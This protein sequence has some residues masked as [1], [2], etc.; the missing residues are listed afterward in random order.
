ENQQY[1]R[2]YP[3]E[4]YNQ[5]RPWTDRQLHLHHDGSKPERGSLICLCHSDRRL[6]LGHRDRCGWD[7]RLLCHS[8]NFGLLELVTRWE[9]LQTGSLLCDSH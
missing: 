5:L 6:T 7:H 8:G 1:R 2:D 4:E 3:H 9:K